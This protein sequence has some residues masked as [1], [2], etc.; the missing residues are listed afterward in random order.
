[1]ITMQIDV[2]GLTRALE[3]MQSKPEEVAHVMAQTAFRVGAL[4]HDTA[5]QYAPIGP[6]QNIKT[7]LGTIRMVN[8]GWSN[9]RIRNVRKAAKAR[10]SPTASSRPMP[11]ALQDSIQVRCGV[12]YAEIFVPSNSPAGK[13]AV[14]IH[15]EKNQTW[16][17]RGAGTIMKGPQA[18]EK[19]ITRAIKDK[20]YECRKIVGDA[21]AK[22]MEGTK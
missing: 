9:R 14:R 18:D 16:W 22:V 2:S 21:V 8:L 10:R 5:V 17:N 19:F 6:P 11:G 4:V 7:Q 20:A 13:Y 15:D 12:D 3:K 1:M